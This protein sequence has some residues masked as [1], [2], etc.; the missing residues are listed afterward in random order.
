MRLSKSVKTG[1]ENSHNVFVAKPE[2]KCIH[3]GSIKNYRG[4]KLGG[5]SVKTNGAP[6]EHHAPKSARWPAGS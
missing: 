3:E 2:R 5:T 6:V 1:N 4:E